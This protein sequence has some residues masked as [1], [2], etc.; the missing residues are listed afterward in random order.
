MNKRKS[1]IYF[2]VKN[3]DTGQFENI[4]LEDL[5]RS[6]LEDVLKD[7]DNEFL[8]EL[9]YRFAELFHEFSVV[10]EELK[11]VEVEINDKF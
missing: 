10:F 2:R 6:Q 8:K 7:K 1:N 11:H 9:V 4:C 3:L 5:S